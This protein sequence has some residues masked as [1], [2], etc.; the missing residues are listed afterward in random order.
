MDL[1]AE[2]RNLARELDEG[3]MAKTDWA[4]K[5]ARAEKRALEAEKREATSAAEVALRK[6]EVASK[7]VRADRVKDEVTSSQGDVLR[8][9]VERVLLSGQF[10]AMA[11]KIAAIAND[12]PDMVKSKYGYEVTSSVDVLL[13]YAAVVSDYLGKFP[14]LEELA[15]QSSFLTPE[16]IRGVQWTKIQKFWL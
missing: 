7:K 4:K 14:V 12:Y 16:T 11:S 15:S 5:A 2:H 8:A 6:A 9:I 10:S 13:E 3:K 1:L